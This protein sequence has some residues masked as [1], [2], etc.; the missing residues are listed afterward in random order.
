M[1]A[2]LVGLTYGTL[3][4]T[5]RVSIRLETLE[6]DGVSIPLHAVPKCGDPMA[7]NFHAPSPVCV[8]HR[9]DPYVVQL[10]FV[11]NPHRKLPAAALQTTWVTAAPR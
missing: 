6:A 3:Y 4:L 1:T 5:V 7:G 11:N 10:V 8:P 2:R 9:D